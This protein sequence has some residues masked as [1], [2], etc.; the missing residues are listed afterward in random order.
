M[1]IKV[2]G[3]VLGADK[4]TKLLRDLASKYPDKVEKAVYAESQIEMTESKK[5]C[6]MRTGELRDSGKV[7]DPKWEGNVVTCTM[8][9][10]DGPSA[11]Y[12]VAV[13][14]HMSQFSPPNWPDEIDWTVPGTGPKFLES[15]LNE[16]RP[17]MA[18]RIAARV[19]IDKK[20]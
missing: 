4:M 6:P 18:K 7:A 9:Y 13:H 15:V 14:E 20:E 8:S 12:A 11:P 2:T 1:P 5:R 17:Y 3:K 16:S 19:R 10:G